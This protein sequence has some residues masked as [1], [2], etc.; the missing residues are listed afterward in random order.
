MTNPLKFILRWNGDLLDF[1]VSLNLLQTSYAKKTN[2]M[3]NNSVDEKINGTADI[4]YGT[5][6]TIRRAFFESKPI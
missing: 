2:F 3:Q 6:G 1:V 5:C 4:I